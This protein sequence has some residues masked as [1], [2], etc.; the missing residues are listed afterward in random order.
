MGSKKI[1]IVEDNELNLKLALTLLTRGGY[2]P[3]PATNA[4]EAIS[5]VRETLPHLVLM[6]IQLPGMD[7]LAAT[8]HLKADPVTTSIPVVALS[9]HAMDRE[10][11]LALDAGC[12]DYITKPYDIKSF[13]ERI[14]GYMS[15]GPDLPLGSEPMVTSQNYDRC[16]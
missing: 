7:G 10:R 11:K 6:D 16:L 9:A 15:A 4:E 13:L 2:E 8:R 3:V 1:V 5:I 12:C 14:S